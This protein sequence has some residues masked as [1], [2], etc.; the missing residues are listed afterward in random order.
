MRGVMCKD[1]R[2]SFFVLLLVSTLALALGAANLVFGDLNQDEGW[3]LYAA[4]NVARGGVPYRDFFFTQGPVMPHVYAAFAPLW[5]PFGVIGGRALTLALGLAAAALAGLLAARQFPRGRRAAP[6]T[7]TFALTACCAYHSYFTV[8][9]KTYALSSLF[10]VSACLLLTRPLSRVAVFFAGVLFACA[11]ATRIS[12]GAAALAAGVW[13]LLQHRRAPWQWC[14]LAT[15]GVVGLL[16][17]F[18]PFWLVAWDQWLFAN[19][20]HASR[21]GGG[22]M[23]VAGSAARLLRG[24]FPLAV[25]GVC[26]VFLEIRNRAQRVPSECDRNA[27]LWLAAGGAVLALQWMSP[28]PYDDYQVPAMPLIAAAVA[29]VA[30]RHVEKSSF[31]APVAALLVAVVAGFHVV[32]SPVLQSWFFIRQDRFWPVMKP[33]PDVVALTRVARTIPPGTFLLTQDAYLA[34]AGGH[35][36]PRGFEMGPFGYF[37]ELSDAE[38]ARQNV[39]NAAGLRRVIVDS[40]APYAMFSGYAFAMSA[41]AMA[42]LSE[43]ER[44]AFFDLVAEH[45]ELLETVADFGQNH[46]PLTIWKRKE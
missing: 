22:L 9:P 27:V 15:G 41:P 39:L 21:E 28:F 37:A 29:T 12:M 40:G 10:L 38:A 6:W 17:C 45:Y 5:S 30:F 13:L 20:F 46:T 14:A 18:G 7:A 25:M 34:V 16:A 3:Y 8:I 1:S 26:A 31:Q 19:Q 42:R 33:A 2:L 11:T 23:M 24:Y 32:A 43:E 35:H 36:L 4:Q 44:K